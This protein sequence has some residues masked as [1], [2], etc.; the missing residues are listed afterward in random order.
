MSGLCSSSVSCKE[1]ICSCSPLTLCWYSLSGW[2]L[3]R[4]IVGSLVFVFMQFGNGQ[5]VQGVSVLSLSLGWT[6]QSVWWYFALSCPSHSVG[7]GIP[8]HVLSFFNW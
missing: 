7:I 6:G 4:T 8:L 3:L 1:S 5:C 2:V